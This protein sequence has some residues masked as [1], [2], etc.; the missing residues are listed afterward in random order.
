MSTLSSISSE[1]V[2]IRRP[3]EG[4][5]NLLSRE[6][7]VSQ[8]NAGFYS[9]Y[10]PKEVLGRCGSFCDIQPLILCCVDSIKS[11]AKWQLIM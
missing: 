5:L 10:E 6:D 1:G 11:H 3:S 7:S 8:E 9:K 2:L 4:M